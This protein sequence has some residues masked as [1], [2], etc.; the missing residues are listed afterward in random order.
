MATNGNVVSISQP[1]IPVFKG[2][3]YEL[4]SIKMKTMFRSQDPWDLVENGYP[5]P[6]EEA[7]LKE[8]KK[9][10][11]KSLFFIQQ[12]VHESIFSK[13]AATTTAKEAWTTLQLAFQ[14]SSNHDE[15][16]IPSS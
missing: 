6:D 13:I 8:N 12:A 16:S 2:E 5:D 14:G 4:W 7:R 1:E 15:T 10:D 11:S 3:C 9:K